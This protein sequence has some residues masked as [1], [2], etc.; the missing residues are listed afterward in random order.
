MVVTRRKRGAAFERYGTIQRIE[1]RKLKKML[2][3]SWGK[4]TDSRK[5]SVTSEP[6]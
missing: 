6:E 3:D 1:V 5:P 2:K 4:S